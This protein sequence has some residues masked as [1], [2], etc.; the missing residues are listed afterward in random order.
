[1]ENPAAAGAAVRLEQALSSRRAETAQFQTAEP[2]WTP[3]ANW[4]ARAAWTGTDPATGAKLRIEAAAWRGR[5]VFFHIIGPWTVPGR[6][7]QAGDNTAN[8]IPILVI[9]CITVI[10][11]CVLGWHNFRTGK[12]DQ[13]GANSLS[14]IFFVC[15]ASAML[16]GM[17]HTA[18][19][20]EMAGIWTTISV[21]M[22][23]A[24]L[25]WG[26]YVALEP[27]VR[28]KWP[29]TMISWTRYTSKGVS[30]PLVGRDLLYGTVLAAL[31]ALGTPLAVALKG[32]NRQPVFPPLDALL[33]VRAE[34]AG[35]VAAVPGAIFTALLFFF[36]LFLLRLVLRKEWI[37]GIMFVAIIT[38]ATAFG[39]T[40]PWVDY[41][42]SA[43]GY[44]IF[45]FALLRFGLLA[46]IVTSA[47]AQILHLGLLLDF[48]AWYAGM[49]VMPFV[50]I[51]LLVIYGF[52]VSLG[53][54]Q[55]FKQEL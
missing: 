9:M 14:V 50:M 48:S 49:A 35:V 13:R 46:A 16:L 40:T 24:T 53:G 4:D 11:A 6:M 55:L 12:A 52:R 54:R 2:H 23:T 47:V 5:P 51:A 44:A 15:L 33:G 7:P 41:P 22:F 18:T 30:D 1:M 19:L 32:Y 20:G 45:A 8:S 10:A 38:F 25:N 29:R 26:V 37:A 34:L 28:R 39:S 27:W 3:L 17:H 21:A 43:L 42:L 36:M 31:L